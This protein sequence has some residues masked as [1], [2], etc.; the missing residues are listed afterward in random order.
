VELIAAIDLL[1]GRARRLVRGDFDAATDGANA[2]ALAADWVAA[3]V[4]HLHVVDL[5]G[6]RRGE[7]VE[8]DLMGDVVAAAR[9][10]G[11]DR[12]RVQA[13]GGLRSQAAVGSVL[14]RGADQAILG[15]AAVD[16][17]GFLAGCA[18]RWPGRILASVDVRG[19]AAAVDGWLRGATESPLEIARRLVG[20]GAAAVIVT[21]VDRDGTLTGPNL[22]LLAEWRATLPE[23]RLIAAG[24]IGTLDDLRRVRD[25]G[26]DGVIA[27][28]ALLSG[29][30]RVGEALEAL[31]AEEIA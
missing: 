4:R 30:L 24:G 21:D 31:A 14:E 18:S 1:G 29:A 20:E 15:T 19:G 26:L 22:A 17:P 8:L 2:A 27:G 6:A 16:Q 23:V 10:A 28:M 11:G 5:D 25:I 9:A 3:G 13:G 7:P 12:V